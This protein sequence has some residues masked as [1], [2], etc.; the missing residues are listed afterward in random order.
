MKIKY[1]TYLTPK[2][3][4]NLIKV[5]LSFIVSRMLKKPVIWGM[6]AAYSIEPTNLCNLKCPECPSGTG[7]L[8][9]KHGS[10]SYD[11]FVS[12]IDQ[13]KDTALY[14]QLFFQGEPYLNKDLTK[15]IAYA[16]K[17]RLYVSVSTNGLMFNENN[18]DSILQN[19]PDKLIFSLDGLDEHSYRKYRVGGTFAAADKSLKMLS[20]K[21][22]ER[23]Q[24]LP[25]IELRFLVMKHNEHQIG[26]AKVYSKEA[27]AD[28]IYFKSMQVYS[29]ESADELL[30]SKPEFNRY[31]T[32]TDALQIKSEFHNYC[33]ALWKTCVITWQGDVVP[34]CFDKDAGYIFGNVLET[35]AASLWKAGKSNKFR[36]KILTARKNI[37]MCT[38]CT[39]GLKIN[40]L[41]NDH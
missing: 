33:F 36:Q 3:I 4:I 5:T 39:E 30:P 11:N 28:R 27:G 8:T 26:E 2:R 25:F 13:I 17:C 40:I 6:P 9:R 35:G 7:A 24:S 18:I 31:K 32:G 16:R 41:N 34:C 20:S 12:I 19:P 21:R 37:G 22:N 14:I 38:N 1:I 10:M 23:K 29:L 15:M